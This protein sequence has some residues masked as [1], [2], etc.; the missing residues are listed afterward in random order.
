MASKSGYNFKAYIGATSKSTNIAQV[1]NIAFS[2][3]G[4]PVEVS[5]LA[6]TYKERVQGLSDWEATVSA[7]YQ[8]TQLGKKAAAMAAATSQIFTIV[9]NKAVPSTTVFS[10]ICLITRIGMAFPMG[11]ATE[12]M[13]VVGNGTTPSVT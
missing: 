9:N 2:V 4:E 11:A 1:T 13:T 3:S 7:N 6:S 5:D 8:T 12:E 10:G